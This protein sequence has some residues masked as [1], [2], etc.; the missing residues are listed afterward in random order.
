MLSALFALSL[1]PLVLPCAA[2]AQGVAPAAADSL[3]AA[4]ADSVASS[5][6]NAVP[7]D[8]EFPVALGSFTTT[9][10]GS[11]PERTANIRLAAEALDGAVIAPPNKSSNLTRTSARDRT[12]DHRAR[13]SGAP[14]WAYAE[15]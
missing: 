14:S 5:L 10:H 6:V 4:P 15:V 11:W 1:L 2:H 12:G 8:E 7:R 3:V 9:L 13:G